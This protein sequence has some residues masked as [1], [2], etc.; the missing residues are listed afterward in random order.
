[1]HRYE[2]AVLKVLKDGKPLS[3]EQLLK[4][5]G[6]KLDEALWAIGN[7]E[8]QHMIN[9]EK[10]SIGELS[11]SEEGRSYAN[12][13]L[14]EQS[15]L[16]RLG[17]GT[18]KAASLKS[19]A[20]RIG[21]Q[22]LKR[23]G[24]ADI[25][26][27]VLEL[28]GAGA[29]ALGNGVPEDKALK[30]LSAK[31]GSHIDGGSLGENEKNLLQRGLIIIKSATK[32]TEIMI[33]KEGKNALSAPASEGELDALNRSIIVGKLWEGKTFKRYDVSVPIEPA[34]F[35]EM[36]PLRSL[37]SRI[38]DTYLSMGFREMSG[39]IIEPA[40]WSFDSL[41]VQ[42]DHP[43]RAVMDTFYLS[44]PADIAVD[45]PEIKKVKKAHEKAYHE[46]WSEKVASQAILRTHG[47]SVSARYLSRIVKELTQGDAQYE[48]PIKLFGI[49]RVFRNENVDF[50]HLENFYQ[51]DGLIIGNNLT[52]SNLFDV[53]IKVYDSLGLK[54]R[55]V[56]AY[57]PF[58]E[59]GVE[60]RALMNGKEL[61]M[62]GAGMIRKE[63]VGTSRKK[64][65]VLA[66]GCGIERILLLRDNEIRGLPEM[67]NS[68][69][70]W[71]RKRRLV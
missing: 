55:L 26:N 63:I 57:F 49:G 3:F 32:I 64:L 15:L 47:T 58:V 46:K 67:Y 71:A 7:L 68:N 19:D 22:W 52:L 23:K 50:K 2:L 41:F 39:P 31:E 53:L 34:G 16:T 4:S 70:G 35:G 6:L 29:A 61:E 24:Y 36:H 44:N 60:I 11:L 1:M 9:V 66:W 20:E 54:V 12:S 43:A 33:T 38:K 5:S 14:P 69:I 8:Q 21:L 37:I 18:I 65:S 30:A 42:Q 28:T 62:G 45:T 27:G 25:K 17:K 10:D 51:M 13:S 56:P 48:L 59:P 40:F